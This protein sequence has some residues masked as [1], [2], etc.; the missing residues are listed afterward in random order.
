MIWAPEFAVLGL[1]R[2]AFGLGLEMPRP[3]GGLGGLP[4]GPLA[5]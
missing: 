3:R 5:G 2:L 1:V 4:R